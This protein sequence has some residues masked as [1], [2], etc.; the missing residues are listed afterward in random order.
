MR[1]DAI[2]M[3]T[4]D[5]ARLAVFPA[6]VIVAQDSGLSERHLDAAYGPRV[7]FA[8]PAAR[9]NECRGVMGM[10]HAAEWRTRPVVVPRTALWR[11]RADPFSSAR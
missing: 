5:A 4:I 1:A 8:D 2:N 3:R 7:Q 10:A 11:P 9:T 6:Q